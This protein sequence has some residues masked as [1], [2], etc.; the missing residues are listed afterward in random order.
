MSERTGHVMEN[1]IT[2]HMNTRTLSVTMRQV[3]GVTGSNEQRTWSMDRQ[4]EKLRHVMSAYNVQQANR[5][6]GYDS[7][8]NTTNDDMQSMLASGHDIPCR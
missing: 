6:T 2:L 4:W 5:L 8:D 7:A 3:S 1:E